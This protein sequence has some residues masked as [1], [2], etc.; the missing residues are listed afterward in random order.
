M[1]IVQSYYVEKD[2]SV[3]PGA[4]DQF[5]LP[6][7]APILGL[8]LK[9]DVTAGAG[10]AVSIADDTVI[11]VIK[12]GSEVIASLTYGELVA[13]N[14]ILS[15]YKDYAVADIAASGTGTY[16]IVL[17]FG[18]GL[19]DRDYYLDPRGF[20]DLTLKITEP[21][22]SGATLTLNVIALRL[23]ESVGAPKGYLKL[24]TKKAYTSASAVE[25][26]EMDRANPYAAILVGEMDGT[27]TDIATIISH[28]KLNIDANMKVPIDMD[29]AEILQQFGSLVYPDPSNAP[30]TVAANTNFLPLLFGYPWESEEEFLQAHQYGSVVVEATGTAAGSI[31]VTGVEVVR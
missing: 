18:F 25:Y 23:L 19:G 6:R 11:E 16:A 2:K 31:R 3:T 29:S 13:V 30:G 14:Q 21:S 26:I 12:N 8:L 27:S 7:T 1:A 20:S 22:G 24:S 5:S 15:G 9:W 10:A 17:P 4:V 28:L